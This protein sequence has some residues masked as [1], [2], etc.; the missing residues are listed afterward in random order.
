MNTQDQILKI[1]VNTD[2]NKSFDNILHDI[3]ITLKTKHPKYK[4]DIT[5]NFISQLKQHIISSKS[6]N[7]FILFYKLS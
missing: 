7:S 4:I 2:L 5:P 6:N 3:V 1:I